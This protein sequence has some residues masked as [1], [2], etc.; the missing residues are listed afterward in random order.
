MFFCVEKIRNFV[1]Y[2]PHFIIDIAQD[3]PK[4]EPC[5]MSIKIKINKLLD[6]LMGFTNCFTNCPP[7]A[8]DSGATG[9]VVPG[10]GVRWANKWTLLYD[11]I[12]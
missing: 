7:R 12:I 4:L 6:D 10:L 1:L 2:Q 11:Y 8:I 3:N 5:R 9:S